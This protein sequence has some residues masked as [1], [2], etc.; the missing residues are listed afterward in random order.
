MEIVDNKEIDVHLLLG[1]KWFLHQ[2]ERHLV[3][4]DLFEKTMSEMDVEAQKI[5]TATQKSE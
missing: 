3:S 2:F 4:E 1:A 5:V